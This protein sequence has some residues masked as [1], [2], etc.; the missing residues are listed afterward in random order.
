MSRKLVWLLLALVVLA[1]LV[2]GGGRWL[3]NQLLIM[4]GI[5]PH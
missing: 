5:H 1:F 2:F 3:W 4:H